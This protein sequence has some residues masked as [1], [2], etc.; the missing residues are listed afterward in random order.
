[1]AAGHR[2]IAHSAS[3]VIAIR[4]RTSVSRSR[5]PVMM[6]GNIAVVPCAA[7]H[8]VCRP[9]GAGQ[10]C[11]HRRDGQQAQASGENSIAALGQS[12]QRFSRN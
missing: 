7:G 4:M 8:G 12:V 3:L 1:L 10:R 9:N 5:F 11:I 2:T 6:L